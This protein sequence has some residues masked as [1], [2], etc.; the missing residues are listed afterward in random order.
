MFEKKV[1]GLDIGSRYIKMALVKQGKKPVVLKTILAA[2]PENCVS[3]GELRSIETTAARI[4]AILKENKITP[5]ELCIS[6]NSIN[7]VVREM[8]LPALKSS[9]IA[10]AVE[11]ELAQSF[12]GI[13]QTH[14]ISSKVYSGPNQPVEGIS[15]FC[16]NKILDGYVELAKQI[17]IPLKS[18]DINANALAKAYSRF[19]PQQNETE[20]LMIVDIGYTTSQVNLVNSG[21]LV[22]SRQIASGLIGLDNMVANRVGI[23]L[24]Q[25]E[26][27]RL[28][29]KYEVYNLGKEDIEGFTQIAFSMVVEQIRQT[30]D[31]YRYNQ[32][33][34]NVSGILLTGGGSLYTGMVD[35][36]KATFNL[37]VSVAD[38]LIKDTT[39]AK[40]IST[41]LSAVGAAMSEKDGVTDINLIPRLREIKA[42]T[43]KTVKMTTGVAIVAAIAVLGVA[44][45]TYMNMT[46]SYYEAEEAMYQNEIKKYSSI[47]DTKTKLKAR[48]DKL[49]NLTAAL[50][51][52]D[53]QL[54]FNT[55]LFN[56]I[57]EV[58]PN[59]VF[60][61]NYS[62]MNENSISISGISQDRV[63]IA[64]FI[65]S[66]KQLAGVDSA[67]ISSVSTRNGEDGNPIDYNFALEIKLKR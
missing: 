12:P 66:L 17:G 21:K 34:A 14:T 2:T 45:Y 26:R 25:A 64:D 46:A 51:Q 67:V 19:V 63:S 40:F 20:T 59:A 6:I 31:Y 56:S 8:K 10:P 16:P 55:A 1:L 37:P 42:A 65:Y 62:F 3:D 30:V 15:A 13:L 22:L 48:Q 58:M 60:S 5:S 28:N 11:F 44:A 36:L 50:E 27:A 39:N 29:Q 41:L 38:P 9:E 7:A 49:T 35:Y 18:L 43:G 57:G 33:K 54:V 52:Y 61:V 4:K 53:N 32:T 47:N 24:E 23:T